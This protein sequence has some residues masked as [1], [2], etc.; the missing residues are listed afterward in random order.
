MTDKPRLPVV[1]EYVRMRG[2]LVE[3]QDIVPPV[4]LVRD[5]IFEDTSARIEGRI[6]GRIIKYFGTYNN[7]Y[8]DGTCVSTAIKAAKQYEKELGKSSM[9]F[10][11]VKVTERVRTQP[12]NSSS[13]YDKK[14]L[15]FQP[16][17]FGAKSDLPDPVEEIVWASD[18]SVGEES[19]GS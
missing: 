16:N 7:F 13:L 19:D 8:G 6:N 11:V 4:V 3:V 15:N 17:T 12:Q 2:K 1:G 14:F 5:Y 18:G 10:V 9:V